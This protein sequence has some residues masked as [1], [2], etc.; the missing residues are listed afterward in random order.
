MATGQGLLQGK[1]THARNVGL[2]PPDSI[3]ASH[4]I[5]GED[6]GEDPSGS[7]ILVFWYLGILIPKNLDILIPQYLGILISQAVKGQEE[8]SFP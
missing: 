7:D 8:Q 1:G 5:R 3:W 2:E 4:K 6:F